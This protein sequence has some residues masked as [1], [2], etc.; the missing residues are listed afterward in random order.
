MTAHGW[1]ENR[2]VIGPIHGTQTN[3]NHGTNLTPEDFHYFLWQLPEVAVKFL[4]FVLCCLILRH[5]A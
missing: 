4:C 5:V 2:A 1:R 3:R